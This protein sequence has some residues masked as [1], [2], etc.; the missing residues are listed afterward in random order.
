MKNYTVIFLLG[1]IFVRVNG[2]QMTI[3]F[4]ATFWGQKILPPARK[5]D[6]VTE[7][8]FAEVNQ[9]YYYQNLMYM[10]K[11]KMKNS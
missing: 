11:L 1:F 6:N 5:L 7:I 9:N 4:K 3:F 2:L 8:C 10:Y